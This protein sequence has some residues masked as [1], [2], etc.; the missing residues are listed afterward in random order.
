MA[1]CLYIIWWNQRAHRRRRLSRCATHREQILEINRQ[2]EAFLRCCGIYGVSKKTDKE[3]VALLKYYCAESEK[4]EDINRYYQ[5]LEQSRFAKEDRSKEDVAWCK[6]LLYDFGQ[7]VLKKKGRLRRFYV[8]G[9]RN[10]R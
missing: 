5:L 1:V 8:R 4:K 7:A 3:Y 10:W 2:M 9:L 6:K